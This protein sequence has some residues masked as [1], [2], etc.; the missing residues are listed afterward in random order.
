MPYDAFLYPG[1]KTDP[2][3]LPAEKVLSKPYF[4]SC[5]WGLCHGITTFVADYTTPFG[6][7]AL[8]TLCKL[9]EAGE[10]FS[11]LGL[12]GYPIAQRKTY[13][14]MLEPYPELERLYLQCDYQFCDGA[15]LHAVRQ[16]YSAA[17]L[18]CTENGLVA[19]RF[20]LPGNQAEP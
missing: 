16:V 15:P 12:Q 4:S 3:Q 19:M 18:H 1:R 7:L 5:R 10:K 20:L 2:L 8:E 11:L 6:L 14:L 9:R 17:G 13:R